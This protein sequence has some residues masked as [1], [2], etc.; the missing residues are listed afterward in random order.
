MNQIKITGIQIVS[1]YG[2]SACKVYCYDEVSGS[3]SNSVKYILELNEALE[4]LKRVLNEGCISTLT[5]RQQYPR[6][7][8]HQSKCEQTGCNKP[9]MYP[10]C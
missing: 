1:G 6:I 9:S 7:H 4:I 8:A 3:G 2:G 10:Y 5:P